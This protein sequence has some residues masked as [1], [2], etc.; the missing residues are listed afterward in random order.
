MPQTIPHQLF[1]NPKKPV[2][3]FLHGFMGEISDFNYFYDQ[4]KDDFYLVGL[5]YPTYEIA[6]NDYL[7]QLKLF[8]E[9]IPAPR[10][11]VGYSM[12]GRIG[13]GLSYQYP[14]LFDSQVIISAH[15]GLK[16]LTE[17]TARAIS[18]QTLL[19]NINDEHSWKNFLSNWYQ[20]EIFADL[21]S[22]PNY[23]KLF[24]KDFKALNKYRI[25]ITNFGLSKQDNF[26]LQRTPTH[27]IVGESDKKYRDIANAFI[28]ESTIHKLS[29]I[30]NSGH[31]CYFESPEISLKLI[32]KTFA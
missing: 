6:F 31:K 9:K 12:G 5:S 13:L 11:F 26:W 16:T 1:G 7:E 3:F 23:Q 21:K 14:D 10:C 28:K 20:Q 24:N 22:H 8:I 25:Q 27:Y 19:G 32:K 4:L 29:V 15:P 17:K 18:D 30:P 2:F